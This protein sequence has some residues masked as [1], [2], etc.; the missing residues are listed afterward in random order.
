MVKSH[1]KP[2]FSIIFPSQSHDLM[3]SPWFFSIAISI[4]IARRA[5]L[6]EPR[7]RRDHGP[8]GEVRDASGELCADAGGRG[9]RVIWQ[10]TGWPME[11]RGDSPPKSLPGGSDSKGPPTMHQV[12]PDMFAPAS[13]YLD[14]KITRSSV[15][16]FHW[17][18]FVCCFKCPRRIKSTDYS[19][20]CR[21]VPVLLPSIP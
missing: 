3:L 1:H 15:V 2:C 16:E 9:D 13:P 11:W 14:K 8:H 19:N 20:C 4:R 12:Y 10:D 21:L 7:H 18:E 6:R 5:G 17:H